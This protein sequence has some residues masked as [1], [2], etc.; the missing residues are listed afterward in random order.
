MN[1]K[2]APKKFS[3]DECWR[4]GLMLPFYLLWEEEAVDRIAKKKRQ[5]F[6][7]KFPSDQHIL[8]VKGYL[9]NMKQKK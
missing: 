6:S 3:M 5:V 9:A 2:S 1:F 8:V 4:R 7:S